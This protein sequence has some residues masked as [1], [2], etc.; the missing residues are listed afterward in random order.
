MVIK[1]IISILLV[2][3]LGKTKIVKLRQSY[4]CGAVFEYGNR[5]THFKDTSGTI[6]LILYK[7]AHSF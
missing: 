3:N 7:M 1:I 5:V 6:M 4:I 2:G